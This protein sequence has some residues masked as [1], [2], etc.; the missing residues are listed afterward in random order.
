MCMAGSLH[1]NDKI[2]RL[3][4]VPVWFCFGGEK[5]ARSNMHEI[6]FIAE[7]TELG[8]GLTRQNSRVDAKGD[9]MRRDER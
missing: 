3:R 6:I 1:W 7:K 9:G 5:E 4:G 2:I 8:L